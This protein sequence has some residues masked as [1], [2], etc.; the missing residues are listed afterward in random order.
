MTDDV[1][2]S[3]D[4]CHLESLSQALALAANGRFGL[5]PSIRE[6]NISINVNKNFIYI[7]TL[8]CL[9]ITKSGIATGELQSPHISFTDESS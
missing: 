6:F 5:L 3:S 7:E 4:K 2:I 1:M 9:A 8:N